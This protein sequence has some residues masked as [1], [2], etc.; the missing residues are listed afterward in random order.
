M[1]DNLWETLEHGARWALEHA[2]DV[3]PISHLRGMVALLRLWAHSDGESYTSWTILVPIGS[4]QRSSPMVRE[5][6]WNRGQ[7]ERRLAAEHRRHKARTK[8]RPTIHVRDANLSAE[9]IDP[10]LAAAARLFVPAKT[11]RDSLPAESILGIE[12]YGSM[13][14]LRME[15]QGPGPVEWADT[16]IWVARLRDLLIASL[17]E[18][19]T[20]GG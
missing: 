3:S 16:I 12:G 9:H 7:D 5:I 19:E 17:K 2:P 6:V 10:Y 18:R 11:F 8:V 15:W 14:Y 20:A 1:V 13:A 4:E